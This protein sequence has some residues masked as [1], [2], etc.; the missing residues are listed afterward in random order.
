MTIFKYLLPIQDCVE[1]DLPY[2]SRVLSVGNQRGEL[3]LW[4]TMPEHVCTCKRFI[5]IVGTGMDAPIPSEARF[6]GTVQIEP[7]VWH[8]FECEGETRYPPA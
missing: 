2:T 1:L 8:V 6:V 7:F 4:A 3:C 5:L